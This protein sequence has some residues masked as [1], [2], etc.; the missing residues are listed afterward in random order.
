MLMAVEKYCAEH[1]TQ[2]AQDLQTLLWRAQSGQPYQARRGLSPHRRLLYRIVTDGLMGHPTVALLQAL[3]P[4]I[5]IQCRIEVE[6]F[7]K[8]LPVRVTFII[9]G[10]CVPGLLV[11]FFALFIDVFLAEGIL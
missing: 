10:L 3:E 4:E 1:K 2:E 8:A 11:L 9:M 7:I 5:Q 6:Q